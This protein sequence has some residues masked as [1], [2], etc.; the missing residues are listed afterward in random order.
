MGIRLSGL[1]S[2]MDT[3]AL[4][5]ALVSSYSLQK[6]NL[7]KAQTKL[8]WKQDSWKTMNKSIYGFYSG[9]LSSARFAKAYSAK[10]ASISNGVYAKVTAS[11]TAVSGT[12]TLKVNKLAATGY[13][14]GGEVSAVDEN[15]N[16]TKVKG[17]TTLSSIKGMSGVESG[18]IMVTANGSTKQINVTK[19]MSVNQF[20]AQLKDAGVNANFDEAN[21]RFFI[22]AKESGAANDF[23]ITAADAGGLNV[24]NSL[25][26]TT[27]NSA[28]TAEYK[29]WAEYLTDSSKLDAAVNADYNKKK[30]SYESRAKMY[31][32]NYNKAKNTMVAI[33]GLDTMNWTP[34]NTVEEDIQLA[35]DAAKNTMELCKTDVDS[36][37]NP[38]YDTSKMDAETLVQYNQARKRVE[39]NEKMLADYKSSKKIV[40]DID[41]KGLVSYDKDGNAVA[42]VEGTTEYDNVKDVVNADNAKI[43]QDIVDSYTAK[44]TYAQ[45]VLDGGLLADSDGAVR[46]TGSDAEIELNGAI[47]TNNT[48]SFSINGLTIEATAVTGA[49]QVSITTGTDVDA[50]YNSIKDFFKEYN[51]LIKAMD[52]AY[53]ASSSKGYE[54][55]TSEE[56]EAM[57]DDEIEKWETKIKDSLL[58][59]DA[60]LGA[61]STVLKTTMASSFVIDGKKY[62]LASF[63]I[64][65][66]GYFDSEANEKGVYH[67]D[68]D[69]DDS[70]SSGSEDKL[71]AAIANNP[72]VVVSFFSQLATSVYNEL[73]KKMSATSLSSVYTIYNDKEMATEY[74]EYNTKISDK[75]DEITKWEDYYYKKFSSME[76]ALAKLNS[77]SSS[78]T[79]FFG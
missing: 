23:S 67:I 1:Q 77:Q 57:T 61:T 46:I 45:Q 21:G 40:D 71:R 79:G 54:P 76:S 4:V 73:G 28:D 51:T 11:S 37:G 7:V 30:I 59:K 38:V 35:I 2:G 32:D 44:A 36:E 68:G 29:K 62:S 27:S 39:S 63:G 58:R 14:T 24:L 31:A 6:D 60:T 25:K 70:V 42:A 5:S 10:A 56:K 34:G 43:R 12:Q 69:S 26:L 13:L 9:K 55:L 64:K 3:E 74:S 65:T 15:G 20:V 47:F 41:S 16:E 72:D 22:S 8:S 50:V 53:N 17:S 33:E 19:D 48:N 18:S 66:Q 49:E 52:T 78:L 75:E